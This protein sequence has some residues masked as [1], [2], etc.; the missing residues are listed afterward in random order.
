MNWSWRKKQHK[1]D[2]CPIT[3]APKDSLRDRLYLHWNKIRNFFTKKRQFPIVIRVNLR[4]SEDVKVLR[5]RLSKL[6]TNNRILRKDNKR[7]QTI[8][9]MRNM[10]ISLMKGKGYCL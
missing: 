8:I 1:L 5:L 10:E 2:D 7:L 9:D 4:L 6:D 3:W